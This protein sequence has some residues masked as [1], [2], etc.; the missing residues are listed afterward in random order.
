MREWYLGGVKFLHSHG[1]SCITW[2]SLSLFFSI[3][4]LHSVKNVL[5]AIKF[6]GN[7]LYILENAEAEVQYPDIKLWEHVS[8]PVLARDAFSSLMW[9]FFCLPRPFL[10]CKESY[11][12][13]VHAFYV[14]N[15]TKVKKKKKKKSQFFG[16]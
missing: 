11:L 3:L 9:T 16:Y 7:M 5:F 1:R 8:E 6:T 14:V 15:V 4:S 10:S 12:S 2:H 13:L